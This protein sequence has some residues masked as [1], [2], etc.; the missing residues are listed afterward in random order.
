[1]REAWKTIYDGC[2]EDIEAKV[3]RFPKEYEKYIIKADETDE[4]DRD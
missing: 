3:E 2:D 4:E 1:M